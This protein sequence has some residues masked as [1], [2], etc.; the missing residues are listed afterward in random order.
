MTSTFGVRDV[1]VASSQLGLDGAWSS[2]SGRLWL[3][4]SC[5]TTPRC[6]ISRWAGPDTAGIGLKTRPAAGWSWI[7]NTGCEEE[8]DEEEAFCIT[9]PVMEVMIGVWEGGAEA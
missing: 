7:T 4:A 8:E 9:P 1:A 3:S 2:S 5:T 6:S